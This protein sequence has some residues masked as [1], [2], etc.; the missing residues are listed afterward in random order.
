[1]RVHSP[2]RCILLAFI[3]KLHASSDRFGASIEVMLNFIVIDFYFLLWLDIM[4]SLDVVFLFLVMAWHYEVLLARC[5]LY[6]FTGAR[7]TY[8]DPPNQLINRRI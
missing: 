1:M 3:G 7:Q 4:K 5:F 8:Q 2:R 6:K